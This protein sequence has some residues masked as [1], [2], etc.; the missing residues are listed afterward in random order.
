MCALVLAVVQ[1]GA[2]GAPQVGIY[3]AAGHQQYIIK[4]NCLCKLFLFL[5][6]NMGQ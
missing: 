6:C 5:R 3:Y 2:L 1:M 4:I